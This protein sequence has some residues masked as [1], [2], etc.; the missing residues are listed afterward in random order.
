M[1]RTFATLA[2]LAA[3]TASVAEAQRYYGRVALGP[4]RT[5]AAAPAARLVSC[6]SSPTNRSPYMNMDP[7]SPNRLSFET[8]SAAE[9]VAWAAKQPAVAA[10]AV[11]SFNGTVATLFQTDVPP[12]FGPGTWTSAPGTG[13]YVCSV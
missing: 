9:A 10:Y 11:M 1:I 6:P 7:S 3:S 12:E 13:M 8:K 4:A 2:A 5:R